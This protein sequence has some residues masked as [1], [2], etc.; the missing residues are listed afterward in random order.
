MDKQNWSEV[1]AFAN[2]IRSNRPSEFLEWNPRN[3][4]IKIQLDILPR[5][6]LLIEMPTKEFC[7]L[8]LQV[9]R[10]RSLSPAETDN[11]FGEIMMRIDEVAY[12]L[13]PVPS[14]LTLRDGQFK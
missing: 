10:D 9:A 12:S 14:K 13:E 11:L 8:C 6:S 2:W 5:S 4:E 1:E 3:S 7:S